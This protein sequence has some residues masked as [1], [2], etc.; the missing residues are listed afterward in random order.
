MAQ[1]V[2]GN[3]EGKA[4]AKNLMA[5]SV[6][7]LP[8]IN[9]PIRDF[10]VP[11]WSTKT[12]KALALDV[13]AVLNAGTDVTIACTGGHG[14]SGMIAA[15]LLQLL[16][17]VKDEH[18]VTRLRRL[19]CLNAI[20][21]AEQVR[22]V[23]DCTGF[24]FDQEL[25]IERPKSTTVVVTGKYDDAWSKYT[26]S[27]YNRPTGARP[28]PLVTRRNGNGVAVTLTRCAVCSEYFNPANG[29]I[30]NDEYE[31]PGFAI[32]DPMYPI[33]GGCL[34]WAQDEVDKRG[35]HPTEKAPF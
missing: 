9:L 28:E 21:T 30:A 20:E 35:P 29:E 34:N 33:C 24:P 12:L 25:V 2:A 1:G 10:G 6:S 19:H 3:K 22:Y 15:I 14:R 17:P 16:D 11:T 5:L 18:P 23:C 31:Y 8:Y 4:L 13:R 7:A 32:A 27:A 26:P